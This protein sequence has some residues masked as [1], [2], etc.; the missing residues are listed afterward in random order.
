[1]ENISFVINTCVN[2][3]YHL[4][5]LLNSLKDNLDNKK[6]EII[7]FIDSDNQD[8][9]GYLK[10]IKKDF[11]D[12]KIITHKLPHRV[13]YQRNK[14]LLVK[15][16]K[17]DIISYLQSDMVISPHYDTDVLSNLEPNCILSAARVEPPLHGESDKTITKDFGV[18][19]EKFDLDKWNSYSV[20]VK[21][22]KTLNYFF[23]PLT[24]YKNIWLDIG[25][26]D[27]LFR[28]SREDSDFVQRCLHKNI[29][30]KYTFNAIVYHFTCVSSRGKDWF[31][32]QNTEA[33]NK[34]KLQQQ[35]DSIE[36]RKF[37]RKWGSFSHENKVIKYDIDLNV[38]NCDKIP[39]NLILNIEP[40][41]SRVWLDNNDIKNQL[42]LEGS[43]ENQLAN[44][45]QGITEEQWEKSK[46]LFN[47]TKHD[48]I[49]LS[50]KDLNQY[51]ILLTID[52]S[53]LDLSTDL[54]L[55]KH[56]HLVLKENTIGNYEFGNIQ[57]DI[58]HKKPT[59]NIIVDNP[60]FDMNLLKIE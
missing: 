32:P 37:L 3:L 8:T 11:Y 44:Y 27:T 19:P 58:K 49:F 16:A 21:E 47:T 15:I 52:G 24:F 48:D 34:L 30:L 40:L 20:S 7:I 26:Y 25:G 1:M 46:H 50:K 55:F 28:R 6:H 23:A 41:F 60:P 18:Y 2:E 5:L 14:N 22:D 38:N 33:Q 9:Y 56:L 4:K 57:I 43:K 42:I 53:S 35:A 29:K 59:T 17:Y 54:E 10:S 12:L 13:A 39:I 45:L 51:N 36:V 31:N